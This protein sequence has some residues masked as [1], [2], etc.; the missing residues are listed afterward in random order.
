VPLT[1]LS[2]NLRYY[3][4]DYGRELSDADSRDLPSEFEER[5]HWNLKR[6]SKKGFV[7]ELDEEWLRMTHEGKQELK[8]KNLI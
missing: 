2:D 7:E 5:V 8:R 4:D 6:L 1:D 3:I